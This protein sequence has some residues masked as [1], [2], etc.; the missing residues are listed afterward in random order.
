MSFIPIPEPQLDATPREPYRTFSDADGRDWMVWRLSEEY[1][2]EIREASSIRRA[3]LVFL[4]PNGETRRLAPVPEKWR[5]MKDAQL[6]S[7]MRTAKPFTPRPA[8]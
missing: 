1:V 4:G 7:L 2:E 8:R 5:R 3:W 6:T